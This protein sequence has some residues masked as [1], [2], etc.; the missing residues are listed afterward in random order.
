[1]GLA[2]CFSVFF[3]N[4]HVLATLAGKL[5]GCEKC[6]LADSIRMIWEESMVLGRSGPGE[7]TF[8]MVANEVPDGC[9]VQLLRSMGDPT[10]KQGGDTHE[11]CPGLAEIG[12]LASQRYRRPASML[13]SAELRIASS[14]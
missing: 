10:L 5:A 2:R 14:R 6:R 13:R 8:E 4:I 7:D 12:M 9:R 3:R 1:M 11:G